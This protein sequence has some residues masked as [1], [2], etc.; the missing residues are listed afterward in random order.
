MNDTILKLGDSFECCDLCDL[1]SHITS[2]C[3]HFPLP[4]RLCV[5]VCVCVG[6]GGGGGGGGLVIMVW[7][8]PGPFSVPRPFFFCKLLSRY[9]FAHSLF[10]M[11]V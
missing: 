9:M 11:L 10:P 2:P 6:G 8:A 5:C 4:E 7:Y 1:V 3:N